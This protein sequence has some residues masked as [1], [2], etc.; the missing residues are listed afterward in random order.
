MGLIPGQGGKIPHVSR[1][2]NQ[3]IHTRVYRLNRNRMADIE[4]KLV[5]TSGEREAAVK[6]T[7]WD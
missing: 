4:N 6:L 2:K 5:V 7:V 3:D 1:P